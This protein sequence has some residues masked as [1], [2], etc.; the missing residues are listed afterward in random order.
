MRTE[1]A[2]M[3]AAVAA[4]VLDLAAEDLA[5]VKQAPVELLI[6]RGTGVPAIQPGHATEVPGRR[7]RAPRAAAIEI[8]VQDAADL[9]RQLLQH[10]GPGDQLLI[11]AP[12]CDGLLVDLLQL[13]ETHVPHNRLLNLDSRR[14]AVFSDKLQTC[15]WLQQHAIPTIPTRV[16]DAQLAELCRSG[17]HPG[18]S[19]GDQ[20]LLDYVM[21][22]RDGA[23]SD[24]VQRIA[25]PAT[26]WDS[27]QQQP[28]AAAS[29]I[30]QPWMPGAPCSVGLIGGGDRQPA[31][32]LK[33][34]RQT[35]VQH[36]QQ[37]QYIGGSLPVAA[38]QEPSILTVAEQLSSALGAFYG[39]V[40]IDLLVD[41]AA[42]VPARVVEINPRLCT[43][44]VGYRALAEDNLAARLLLHSST[45]NIRWRPGCVQF[46]AAGQVT[47][48]SAA[49]DLSSADA[50]TISS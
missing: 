27:L 39:Y 50:C 30:I 33:P 47:R 44:Y 32:I 26:L 28:S 3:L 43:S 12:E 31:V 46:D 9:P 37:L 21:K 22:P 13:L 18:W 24:H 8:M 16:I 19:D 38:A 45:H 40:G 1:A 29:L 34:A 48:H 17:H 41:P 35:V 2:A 15:H 14:S 6:C 5:T 11:I 7:R 20:Q 36:G 42:D 49:S 4:D 23:G 10:A 25:A